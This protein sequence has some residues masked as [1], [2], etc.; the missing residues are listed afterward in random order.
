MPR[1]IFILAWTGCA[2]SGE[3]R[4]DTATTFDA[5]TASTD[6][7]RDTYASPPPPEVEA[8]R[9]G[10]PPAQ[11]DVYVFIANPDYDSVTRVNVNTSEVRTTPVGVHPT[12][13]ATT[14]DYRTSVVFNEGDDSVSII[15]A[16]T[17]DQRVVDVRANLNHLELTVDGRWALL[18]RDA[19]APDAD[20]TADGLVSYNEVS[21][22]EL[23]TGTH[24]PIVAGYRPRQALG[25]PD[26]R[27]VAL[28]SD[29]YLTL[30]DVSGNEPLP[31]LIRLEPDDLTPP[32][33]EEAILDPSGTWA[34]VRQFG[35]TDLLYVDL[36]SQ[37]LQRVPVGDNPTDLDMAP[38]GRVAAVVARD[39][40]SI[41]ILDAADP[42]APADV[43]TLPAGLEAG[44][45]Q[46]ASD[47][48]SAVLY[49]TASL[50]DRYAVWDVDAGTVTD[51]SLVKPAQT[52]SLSPD[53]GTLLV[54]HTLSDAPGTEA[55]FAGEWAMSMIALDSFVASPLVLPSEPTGYAHSTDGSH[56]YFVMDGER[57]LVRLD[58][59][60][61]LNQ[62]VALKSVP[63]FLGV[64]PDLTPGDPD[65][66]RTWVS[67]DHSLG[68]ISF[69]DPDDGALET[70]TGFELN[71][72]IEE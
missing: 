19:F 35:A 42:L 23:A 57:S 8:D 17:L 9:L 50:I 21:F 56:G 44:Q 54:F 2:V 59:A 46:F 55:P 48:K 18:W 32:A 62:E 16:A 53:G 63:V 36:V 29:D 20:E 14:S 38:D 49:T 6:S 71:S 25:T 24:W 52:V 30:V 12:A 40:Q 1:L 51:R 11:T 65:S 26:G 69:Y 4:L 5:S 10:L 70:L 34:M 66:P 3:W 43:V 47:A 67:Q 41:W 45:L 64:L 7:P 68:R 39:D 13:V 27:S 37:G 33:A 28:I 15:D 22:V 61:L 60:T 31:T 72:G 58:Y